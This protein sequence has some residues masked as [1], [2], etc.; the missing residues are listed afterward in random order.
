MTKISFNKVMK[1]TE[2]DLGRKATKKE[3]KDAKKLFK[4]LTTKPVQKSMDELGS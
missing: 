3:I 2:K 4:I 1:A